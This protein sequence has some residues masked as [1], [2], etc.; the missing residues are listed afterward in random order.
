MPL[1]EDVSREIM[2]RV[3][4][5]SVDLPGVLTE[6]RPVRDYLEHGSAAHLCCNRNRGR[7]PAWT[8]FILRAR[9]LP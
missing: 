7:G 9:V 5:H 6:V 4:E 8:L 3:Q 1:A 2:E